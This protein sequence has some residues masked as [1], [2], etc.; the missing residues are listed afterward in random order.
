ME[1]SHRQDILEAFNENKKVMINEMKRTTDLFTF[2][3]STMKR[4]THHMVSLY[5]LSKH[6]K[7]KN[8]YSTKMKKEI[9][10]IEKT[11]FSKF[12]KN[13]RVRAC[14]KPFGIRLKAHVDEFDK[15][16][17]TRVHIFIILY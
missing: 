17:V 10:N 3:S 15:V 6:I 8:E 13:E 2:L 9:Q 5:P 12:Q 1:I 7:P 11:I 4:I 16:F 14:F